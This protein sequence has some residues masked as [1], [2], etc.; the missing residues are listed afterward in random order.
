MYLHKSSHNVED[1]KNQ[2]HPKK[3]LKEGMV[4]CVGISFQ[5]YNDFLL[6]YG[7]QRG[8]APT[9]VWTGRPCNEGDVGPN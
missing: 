8:G 9:H 4:W 1:A 5:V 3:V 2:P 7:S 6:S